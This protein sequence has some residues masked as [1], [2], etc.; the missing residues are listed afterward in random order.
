[1]RLL[2]RS[3]TGEFNTE[4]VTLEDLTNGTGKDKPGYEKVRFCGE[5]TA[6]DDL[7]YFWI[8]TCCINKS[9]H[10]ELSQAINS[11]FRWYRN[12]TRC[13]V[14]LSDV[15]GYCIDDDLHSHWDSDLGTSRW[16]TRGWTLQELLAPRS[17][18]FFS[19]ERMRIGD[20]NSLKQQIQQITGVPASAL[21]E[22][23][24]SQFSIEER[25]L[26]MERRQT[27]LAEN[28]VYALLGIL[29]VEI[30]LYYGEGA[31]NASKRVREVIDKRERCTQ[32]LRLTDPRDDKKRIEDTKGGLLKNSNIGFLASVGSNGK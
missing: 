19:C 17:V 23:P 2:R 15:K 5:Q 11:M 8:D 25:F 31:G 12:A 1:M 13:Y 18:E 10:V 22:A 16:F 7:E 29:D 4:E 21:Q 30:P 14:Y 28:K 24:L 3:D 20:R 6:R 26:W 32:D 27:K 9:N